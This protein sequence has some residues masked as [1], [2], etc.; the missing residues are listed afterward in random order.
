MR[1]ELDQGALVLQHLAVS[2]RYQRQCGRCIGPTLAIEHAFILERQADTL[3]PTVTLVLAE[4][5]HLWI[6]VT[7]MQQS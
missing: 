7:K 2:P 4:L 1:R 5:R 6:T 3:S